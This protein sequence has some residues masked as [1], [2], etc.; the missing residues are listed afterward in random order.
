MIWLLG[1][2]MWLFVHR[3]F[4]VWPALGAI[5]LERGY[6]FM[7][8]LAWVVAPG[9]G[10]VP[11]RI[12]AAIAVFSAVLLSAWVLSPY[13]DRMGCL[14]VVENFAKVMV[15]YVLVVTTVRDERGLRLLVLLFL[16]ANALYMAHSILEMMNGRYQWRMGIRR[17]VGVD[18]TFGD[19][20]AFASTLLYT[21]PL[22][23]PFWREQPRRVPRFVLAG[24]TLAALFCILMT[25]SRAGFMGMVGLG[26]LVLLATAKR[27]GQMIV[28]GGFGALVA[29]AVL[30]VVLPG[31]LQDRYLTLVDSSHG[32]EN[33]NVSASGRLA[34]FLAGVAAWQQSPLI[35]HGPASFQYATGRE[36]Q[37]HNV[38]GQ[39][40]SELGTMGALALL[41][42][43]WCF[44][45][46]WLESR[47]LSAATWP[48]RPRDFATDV[49]QAVG[50][51]AI[52]LLV[53]G[54]AGH[55][56]Y[57]YNWEWFAAFQAIALH[58][59]RLRAGA[60]ADAY[61][62]ALGYSPTGSLRFGEQG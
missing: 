20:N 33:A 28:M 25:G 40:L 49:V 31:E 34:G 3:P 17:M 12:H 30:S 42:L 62:C 18:I 29:F 11:N 54:W 57:R 6:V 43:V 53:M 50:F 59:V 4:E 38:Y 5:Q 51:D 32:P 16:A 13:A 27:K 45:S 24:Y 22:T 14:D 23:L 46:N 21:L 41:L 44:F 37:A 56:L 47:R 55:N 10:F 48:P 36:G 8:L 7:M 61:A 15:F 58:C 9:K 26:G 1:G 19:P 52:L 35:G 2:Y 60:S 39:V